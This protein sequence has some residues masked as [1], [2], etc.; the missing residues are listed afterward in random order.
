[1]K[2]KVIELDSNIYI[3]TAFKTEG[4]GKEA[5]VAVT[6]PLR[7]RDI[8]KY[9]QILIR[10][11]IERSVEVEGVDVI[12]MPEVCGDSTPLGLCE[13]RLYE[14]EEGMIEDEVGDMLPLESWC[15]YAHNYILNN[16]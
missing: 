15:K 7:I 3:I 11:E 9:R 6:H 1:M 16:R 5:P 8:D 14:L 12:F 10:S 13:G 2:G 4:V